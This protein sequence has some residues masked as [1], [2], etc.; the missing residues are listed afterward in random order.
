[1]AGRDHRGAVPAP[2]RHREPALPAPRHLRLDARRPS[3]ARPKGGGVPGGA[4]AP[5]RCWRT[6]YCRRPD[7]LRRA[8]C[9]RRGPTSPPRT[10]AGRSTAARFA[11]GAAAAGD[12]GAPRPD[13]RARPGGGARDPAAPR[14]A[15][16]RLRDAAP[17][18]CAWGQAALRRLRRLRRRRRARAGRRRRAAGDGALVA[19]LRRARGQGADRRPSCPSSPRSPVRGTTGGFARLRGGGYVPRPHLAPVAGDFVAQA[20]RFVG[21]ALPLGRAQ[22]PRHRLLGAGA[23]RAHRH[24]PRR[25]ARLRHAGGAARRRRSAPRRALA[26]RRPRLLER[27]RRDHARRRDAAARQRP[28]HGG[29]VASRSRRRPRGSPRPAAGRSPRGAARRP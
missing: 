3:P 20:E 18:G 7:A 1:M 2:L 6:R 13:A 8:G 12:R 17:T 16:H 19:G 4:G 22:R 5:R 27:P 25:A 28:P 9:C 11:A 24:R 26:A 14:R 23:A 29:G 10:C 15:L 21:V